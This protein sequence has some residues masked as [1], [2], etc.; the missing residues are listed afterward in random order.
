MV[1]KFDLMELLYELKREGFKDE[2]LVKIVYLMAQCEE[3]RR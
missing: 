2:E 3:Y 1:I